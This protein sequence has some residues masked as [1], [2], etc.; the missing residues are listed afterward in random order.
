MRKLNLKIVPK[1]R[2]SGWG[3]SLSSLSQISMASSTRTTLCCTIP[4]HTWNPTRKSG[5]LDCY[6]DEKWPLQSPDGDP[7]PLLPLQSHDVSLG[8]R[9]QGH[10]R[11]CSGSF[12]GGDHCGRL[13]G[14]QAWSLRLSFTVLGMKRET[15]SRNIKTG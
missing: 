10:D 14:K 1:L 3:Q 11:V 13:V 5:D 8:G 15:T 12:G 9:G 7:A 6:C 4:V 2:K